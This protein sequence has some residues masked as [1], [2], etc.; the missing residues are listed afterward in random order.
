M[1]NKTD[2]R[3]NQLV[4]SAKEALQTGDGIKTRQFAESLLAEFP[5]S[6]EGWLLMAAISQPGDALAQ[7]EKALRINPK[8]ETARQAIRLVAHNMLRDNSSNPIKQPLKDTQPIKVGEKEISSEDDVSNSGN[9]PYNEEIPIFEESGSMDE[10]PVSFE[11]EQEA[12]IFR[13]DSGIN[14]SIEEPSSFQEN[15]IPESDEVNKSSQSPELASALEMPNRQKS[16]VFRIIKKPLDIRVRAEP[17]N[18]VEI[19]PSAK[20]NPPNQ[21]S[22]LN[23]DILEHIIIVCVSIL[24][25]ILLV[26]F[27]HL[28]K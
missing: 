28:R 16:K 13:E 8:S 23:A 17:D 24:L 21:S 15:L 6:E 27:F 11:K 19:I 2:D 20:R 14:L 5:L 4:D 1:K 26:I 7:L 12:E 22:V 10:E 9:V 25:P 18:E 3:F